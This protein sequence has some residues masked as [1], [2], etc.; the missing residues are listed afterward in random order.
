MLHLNENRK[1]Y[2]TILI[3]TYIE[4]LPPLSS[5]GQSARR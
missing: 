3:K 5:A 2:I 1:N 4:T